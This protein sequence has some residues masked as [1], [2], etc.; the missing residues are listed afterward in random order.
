MERKG[1]GAVMES[2]RP[3]G[4]TIIEFMIVVAIGS[5][6]ISIAIPNFIGFYGRSKQAGAKSSLGSVFKTQKAYQ[7]DKDGYSDN[8][9]R[10]GWIPEGEVL[11]IVGFTSDSVPSASGINDTAE[12]AS[13]TAI[14]TSKMV[15]GPLPLTETDL[16]VATV[17]PTSF[18]IGAAANIDGDPALDQWT[19]S[20][21]NVM[22]AVQDDTT[23]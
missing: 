16:P 5:V 8:L 12:L 20:D 4:F 18:T 3:R 22:M 7:A 19:L 2:R 15:N 1:F 23:N 10:I 13:V 21:A 6:L 9:A 14:S 11:Y 17:S